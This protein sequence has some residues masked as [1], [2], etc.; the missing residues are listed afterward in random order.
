[1]MQQ[2]YSSDLPQMGEFVPNTTYRGVD[3]GHPLAA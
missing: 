1:M 3:D 2:R